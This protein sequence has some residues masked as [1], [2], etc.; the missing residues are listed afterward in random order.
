MI[1]VALAVT[2]AAAPGCAT[3]D[4]DTTHRLAWGAYLPALDAAQFAAVDAVGTSVTYLHRFVALTQ[5]VPTAE[6]DAIAGRE[7]TALITIEPWEPAAGV[8]QPEYSLARIADGAFDTDLRRWGA[9]LASWGEPVLVRFGHEMN[10]SW[11]PWA[12][13]VNGNTA[14]DYRRA[15]THMRTVI[16]DAG[17]TNVSFVWAPNVVVGGVAGFADAYP[18]ADQVDVLGLDGYNWGDGQGFTWTSP[19]DL[20]TSSLTALRELPGEHP[21]LISEVGC[22]DDP[23]TS[24]KATWIT[25]LLSMLAEQPR[26]TGVVWFQVDKERDWRFDSSTASAAAFSDALANLP[27]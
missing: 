19:A 12:I 3:S 23:D 14:D 17:A 16:R 6:L 10:G 2:I 21:I 1:V 22:A 27:H 11:Y 8:N 7:A 5:P 25:D 9:A 4:A 24:R 13:G 15:W 20:F 26:V 18:G